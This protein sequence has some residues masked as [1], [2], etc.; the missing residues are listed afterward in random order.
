MYYNIAPFIDKTKSY[1]VF[2]L[3]CFIQKIGCTYTWVYI[4]A[5]KHINMFWKKLP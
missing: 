3:V 5:N 2:I 4:Y 1:L